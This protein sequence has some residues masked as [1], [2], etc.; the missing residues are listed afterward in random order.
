MLYVLLC[1]AREDEIMALSQDQDDA[2]M[3]E[4]A[5]SAAPLL[6]QGKLGPTARLLPTSTATTLRRGAG[7]TTLDGPFSE[8]KEQLLG[9]YVVDCETLEEALELGRPFVHP[10][11][12][13]EVRPVMQ[14]EPGTL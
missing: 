2:L 14:F 13:I 9:F 10:S 12:A 7:P 5:R 3:A 8:T 4:H 11:G 1:Y 6:A